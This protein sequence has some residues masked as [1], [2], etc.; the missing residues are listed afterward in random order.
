MTSLPFERVDP[1]EGM[2]AG[3]QPVISDLM[4]RRTAMCVTLFGPSDLGNGVVS[5]IKHDPED[6]GEL[7]VK[8]TGTGFVIHEEPQTRHKIQYTVT[9]DRIGPV[10]SSRLRGSTMLQ[11]VDVTLYFVRCWA[12]LN[13]CDFGLLSPQID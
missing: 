13:S 3:Y 4:R 11:S 8:R 12:C 1:Y 2:D 5:A 7:E 10:N 9:R 6:S